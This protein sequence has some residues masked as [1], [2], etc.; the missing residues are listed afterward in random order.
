MDFAALDAE[1]DG[2]GV[3]AEAVPMPDAMS[4]PAIAAT[5]KARMY[6]MIC[7]PELVVSPEQL[8]RV[9]R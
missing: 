8:R 9:F 5:A 3:A 2:T 6:F 4:P 1:P 7:P